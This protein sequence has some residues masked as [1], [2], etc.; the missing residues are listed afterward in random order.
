MN[1]KDSLITKFHTLRGYLP[2]IGI[3]ASPIL[4]HTTVW[5]TNRS[6]HNF[7]HQGPLKIKHAP[8]EK[9]NFFIIHSQCLFLLGVQISMYLGLSC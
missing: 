5:D 4:Y 3:K 7:K 9:K 6:W 1:N 8:W 2:E